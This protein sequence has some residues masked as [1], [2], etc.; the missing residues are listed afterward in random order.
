MKI[1]DNHIAKVLNFN[2]KPF[3]LFLKSNKINQNPNYTIKI[4]IFL[5]KTKGKN[6]KII[7]NFI[8]QL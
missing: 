7:T 3:N 2:F 4:S 8:N 5:I 6:H 1:A